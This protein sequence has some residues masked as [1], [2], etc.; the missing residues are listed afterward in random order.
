MRF[1]GL[2]FWVRG[3]CWGG[4]WEWVAGD[5]DVVVGGAAAFGGDYV[6]VV[7]G[8]DFVDDAHHAFGPVGI[9]VGWEE[10]GFFGCI[11]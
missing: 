2:G 7:G 5:E 10:R 9:R 1:E 4:V 3:D 11:G 6:G 8:G